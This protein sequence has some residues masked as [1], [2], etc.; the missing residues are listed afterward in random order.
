[1]HIDLSGAELF[2]AYL[3]G[4]VAASDVLQHPAYATVAE[5]ARRYSDGLSSRDLDDALQQRQSRFYGLNDLPARLPA[6][7]ALMETIDTE[8]ASWMDIAQSALLRLLPKSDLDIVIY[9]IIGHDMGIGLHGAVCMNC[10]HAPYLA[11][12]REFL[13]FMIHEC[14]HVLYERC[15][16][17]PALNDVDSPAEWRSYFNLWTQNEGFA[18][19]APLDLR[20]QAGCLA[21]RDYAVLSDP[22]ELERARLAFLETL[23][24]LESNT[25]RSGEEY[26]ECCFGPARLT[27]RI[28]C[29]LFRR[30]ERLGGLDAVQCAFHLDADEFISQYRYLLNT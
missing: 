3:A 29:E 5:H 30:I 20:Q 6:V 9:P 12:P 15:H 21:D 18:V 2:L 16:D 11:G 17:V 19:Y 8:Q 27:Y 4:R 22:V 10:N 24:M 1:M 23:T 25:P 26:I 13:F 28:G 7:Q 14:A